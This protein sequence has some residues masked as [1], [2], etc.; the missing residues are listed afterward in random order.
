MRPLEY[1]G[2]AAT[3]PGVLGSDGG[4]VPLGASPVPEQL[5][6][7]RRCLLAVG[8][9]ASPRLLHAKLVAAGVSS[10]VGCVPYEVSGL[11]VAHSAQV[12]PGG[13]VATTAYA[14]PGTS[15]R[16]VASWFDPDQVA[17]LDA[18]EPNYRRLPLPAGVQGAPGRAEV[19]VSRWGVLAPRGQ[20]LT[21][22][23]QPEVHA[24]L[25]RDP[26]LARLLPLDDPVGTVQALR[27][28][29]V[30]ARVRERLRELGWVASTG[31][32]G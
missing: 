17:A 29:E 9:N 12:S 16:V 15:T 25:A 19:Y 7:D 26:A 18:T 1:P 13:Y 11:G 20:P 21:P 5:V 4:W 6:R 2:Y 27:R 32:H 24:V 14:A 3:E 30:Q 28:P 8:S 22:R 10:P 23:S 31:L